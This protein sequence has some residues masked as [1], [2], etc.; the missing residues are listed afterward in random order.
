M[1]DSQITDPHQPSD[2]K[3]DIIKYVINASPE[4][5]ATFAGIIGAAHTETPLDFK[6]YTFCEVSK[7]LGISRMTLWRMVKQ[8]KIDTVQTSGGNRRIPGPAIHKY[9]SGK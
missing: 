6:L 7:I 8:G 2:S 4:Q 3:L 5:V 1:S 9:I